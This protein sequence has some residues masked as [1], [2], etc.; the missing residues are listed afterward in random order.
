MD[1]LAQESPKILTPMVPCKM[2][3]LLDTNALIFFLEDSPR[4]KN[5]LAELIESPHSTSFVSMAS[6]WE[7]SLKSSLNKLQVSYANHVDLPG[8]LRNNGFEVIDISWPAIRRTSSLPRHHKDPFDR[9]LT[10]ECQL[11]NLP[12]ISADRQLDNYGVERLW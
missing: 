1:F 3:H 9:L 6:L 5:H 8:A 2:N 10:A 11:R 7:I 12:I 4:L